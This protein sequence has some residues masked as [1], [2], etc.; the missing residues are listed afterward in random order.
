[1]NIKGNEI[2]K[3]TAKPFAIYAYVIT[4]HLPAFVEM[5]AA[6]IYNGNIRMLFHCMGF[7]C[8]IIFLSHWV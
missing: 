7:V 2:T 5:F 4:I 3:I 8:S 6:R 1:M